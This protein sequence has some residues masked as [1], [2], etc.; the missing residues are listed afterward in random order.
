M[1]PG[2]LIIRL[3]KKIKQSRSRRIKRVSQ[4]RFLVKFNEPP[5]SKSSNKN[6]NWFKTRFDVYFR[7]FILSMSSRL[8]IHPASELQ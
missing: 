2:P 1:P 3:D 7:N 8:T 4:E 5:A 6:N